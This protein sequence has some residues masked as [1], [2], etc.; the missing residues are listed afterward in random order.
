MTLMM[1]L[2]SSCAFEN[3]CDIDSEL[4]ESVDGRKFKATVGVHASELPVSQLRTGG[5]ES[6]KEIENMRVMV[7]DKDQKF[8]YTAVALL[9]KD[10]ITAPDK[11]ESYLPDEKRDKIAMMRSFEVELVESSEPRYLH[12]I[13]DF[14]WSNYTQ[15]YFLQGKSAGELIPQLKTHLQN[16]DGN[17]RTT[18]FDP[19]W[20]M[21]RVDALNEDTF[22]DKVI[23]LLRNYAKIELDVSAVKDQ[24]YEIKYCVANSN[25]SGTVAPFR[26]VNYSYEFPFN[27]TEATVPVGVKMHTAPSD[28]FLIPN[29]QH[30]N[31]FESKNDDETRKVC[32][33]LRTQKEMNGEYRYYKIDLVQR[34]KSNGNSINHYIQILRNHWYTLNVSKI[35]SQG[36]SS[37]EE[38]LHAPADNN[39][40]ASVKMKDFSKVSDGYYTLETNPI[41]IVVVK[42]GE[43][44][45]KTIFSG[46]TENVRYYPDWDPATDLYMGEGNGTPVA[47]DVTGTLSEFT[48]NVKQ[49]PSDNIV[50]YVVDVIGLRKS[51]SVD[52]NTGATSPITR[53]VRITLRSPYLFKGKLEDDPAS[54]DV[55]DKL[56]SFQVYKSIPR[57]LIPFEVF[58]EAKGISPR[59]KGAE[60][61]LMLV[62]R[63]LDGSGKKLYYR[64]LVSEDAFDAAIEGNGRIEIP[65]KINSG[66]AQLSSDIRLLSDFYND[67]TIYGEKVQL[68]E[69]QRLGILYYYPDETR[70]WL[71]SNAVN[72]IELSFTDGSDVGDKIQ[73]HSA[74][75]DGLFKLQVFDYNATL[76]AKTLT[77]STWVT[78]LNPYGFFRYRVK[79]EMSVDEW[80]TKEN[81][82]VLFDGISVHIKGALYHPS[83]NYYKRPDESY[84]QYYTPQIWGINSSDELVYNLTKYYR[85]SN[86]QEKINGYWSY[87]FELTIPEE[88]YKANINNWSGIGFGYTYTYPGYRPI[89]YINPS[90]WSTL[91]SSTLVT[92]YEPTS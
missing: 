30:F 25:Q 53:T 28:D 20:S 41:E 4:E 11:D 75:E 34:D 27:V 56:L 32:A 17:K 47:S 38:A 73:L 33:I 52:G 12:F 14:D 70:E 24:F 40:F 66:A 72:S 74:G 92:C 86:Q 3:R 19:L 18:A 6:I 15:D 50:E 21:V 79:K 85:L 88:T 90:K 23:K 61:D 2:L 37:L 80:L 64:Y 1:G 91:M 10:E 63:D 42:P 82:G 22:Q 65:V 9:T 62:E 77:I 51:E 71:P 39:I 26:M 16:A 57:N 13:A 35:D 54:T 44:S 49:V 7:F 84:P 36:Y 55:S 58:I 76:G 8:L 83:T 87:Q 78:K 59:N 89:Y 48:F 45:F 5:I 60:T 43:Y 68:K 81:K 69:V 67:D 29:T 46:K 31:L